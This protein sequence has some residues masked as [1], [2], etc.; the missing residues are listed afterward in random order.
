MAE[1]IVRAAVMAKSAG[2]LPAAADLG[3]IPARFK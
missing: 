1:A 2:G 3:T